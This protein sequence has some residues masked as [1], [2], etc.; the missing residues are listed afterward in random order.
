M[1]HMYSILFVFVLISTE[2]LIHAKLF[3]VETQN[4]KGGKD[5]T[6]V[7]LVESES[8]EFLV[9]SM[10]IGQDYAGN[11]TEY[12]FTDYEVVMD[13]DEEYYGEDDEEIKEPKETKK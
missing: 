7:F 1:G 12:D 2:N 11:E 8:N 13:D 10:K 4:K 9:K 6:K 3:L 5:Q